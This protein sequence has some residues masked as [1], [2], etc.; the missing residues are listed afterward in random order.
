M[1]ISFFPNNRGHVAP[2]SRTIEE[3]F[4]GQQPPPPGD[5]WRSSQYTQLGIGYDDFLYGKT[6]QVLLSYF[7]TNTWFQF[8][9]FNVMQVLSFIHYV[10]TAFYDGPATLMRGLLGY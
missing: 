2:H 4:P 7:V 8:G 9:Y 5:G 1:A 6:R 10:Y 3:E